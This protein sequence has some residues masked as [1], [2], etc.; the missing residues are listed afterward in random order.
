[1]RL[2]NRKNGIRLIAAGLLGYVLLW[3]WRGMEF[4]PYRL[5]RA[6]S[7]AKETLSVMFPPD[8]TVLPTAWK[9][10]VETVQVAIL[11]TFFGFVAALPISFLAARSTALPRVLSSSIKTFLNIVRAIPVY[12]YAIIF[13]AMVGL[14]PFPGALA[15]GVGS[16]V[17]LAKLFAETLEGVHPAP[18]EAVKAV[19]G[20][21]IQVF[22]Y[23]MLPQALPQFLSQTLYAWEINISAATIT[24]IVGAGGIGQ[25]LRT[26][27]GYSQWQ[28]VTVYVLLL[29]GMVLSADMLSYQIR[30]RYT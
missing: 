20:S 10:L 1:M 17:M 2:F 29:I 16:F 24:G 4:E 12:I 27:I 8:W 21:P 19:G 22:A 15:I 5:A 11:G 26:Q 25:E 28:K 14:G 23:G 3:A 30:R 9:K 13:V 6:F 7:N 18:I